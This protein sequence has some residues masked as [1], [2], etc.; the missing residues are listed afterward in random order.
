MKIKMKNN[1]QIK[2]ILEK[3]MISNLNAFQAIPNKHKLLVT[4]KK[5]IEAFDFSSYQEKVKETL[6]LNISSW[7]NIIPKSDSTPKLD[8]L[9]FEYDT[10]WW[11]SRQAHAYGVFNWEGYVLSEAT[12]DVDLPYEIVEELE[13]IPSFKLDFYDE[14]LGLLDEDEILEKEYGLE[15]GGYFDLGGFDELSE[16]VYF[17]GC[18]AIHNTFIELQ[19]EEAFAKLNLR[20]E[21]MML[22]V[23]HDMDERCVLIV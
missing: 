11:K 14:C 18:L 9:L 21:A 15:P 2:I 16:Y 13:H 8:T 6:L 17:K 1:E 22:L 10:T 20:K 5:Q 3:E 12:V 23:E 19:K 4:I 7:E